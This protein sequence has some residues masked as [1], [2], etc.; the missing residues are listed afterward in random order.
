ML[1]AANGP[2]SRA[3]RKRI[4]ASSCLETSVLEEAA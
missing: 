1:T 4:L 3:R 2:T